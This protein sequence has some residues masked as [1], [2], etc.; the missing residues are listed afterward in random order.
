MSPH[1]LA[2]FQIQ[3]YQNEPTFNGVYSRNNLPKIKN[4]AYGINL[5]ECESI[6]THWIVLYVLF[7]PN[8]I[9]KNDQT[10]LKYFQ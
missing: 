10:I 6:G 1:P 9:E 5:N 3:K 2:D 8:K 7:S 4:G